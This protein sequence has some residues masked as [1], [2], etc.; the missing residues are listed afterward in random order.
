MSKSDPPVDADHARELLKRERER[1]E[2]SLAD[3]QRVRGSQLEEI[4]TEINAED[5]GEMI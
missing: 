1:I 5:D 3:Q 4:D 2:R